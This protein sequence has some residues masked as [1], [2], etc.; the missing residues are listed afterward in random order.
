M[1]VSV[2]N[3]L[4]E[5]CDGQWSE[6]ED[7]NDDIGDDKDCSDDDDNPDDHIV[8]CLA[9]MFFNRCVE[10]FRNLPL[11]S[12]ESLEAIRSILKNEAN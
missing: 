8:C 9:R 1:I 4:I 5:S 6:V 7:D 12:L 3:I 11:E 10:T 2:I